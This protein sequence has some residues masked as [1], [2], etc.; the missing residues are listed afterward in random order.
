M[1]ATSSTHRD[2]L[3]RALSLICVK[4]STTSE[5]L[6]HMMITDKATCIVFSANDLPLESFDRTRSIYISVVCS[7]HKVTSL[8]L[9]NGYALNVCPLAT[10]VALDFTPSVFGPST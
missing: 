8:L 1:L 3:I 7:G 9:D 2:V 6:I 5:G 4:I 10:I